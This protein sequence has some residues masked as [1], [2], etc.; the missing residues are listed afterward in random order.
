MPIHSASERY[1]G[2]FERDLRLLADR[3]NGKDRI[4]LLGSIATPKYLEPMLEILQHRLVIPAA[5]IGIGDMSR[6]AL[7]LRAV[8]EGKQLD[9]VQ[10]PCCIAARLE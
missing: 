5:F 10:P 3:L 2:S 6:G 1:R 7:L 4:V 9:Y 8:R